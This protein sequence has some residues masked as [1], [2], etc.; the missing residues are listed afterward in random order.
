MSKHKE[1]KPER[2]DYVK[3]LREID[4]YTDIMVEDIM[5]IHTRAEKYARM[6]TTEGLRV[7]DLMS[8][9]VITVG[10]DCSLADAAHL[11]VSK[12]ISGLPVV[13]GEK[14][15]QGIITEADFLRTLGVPSHHPSHSLWQTLE[16]MF[17]H[18][19]V[20][21]EPDEGTVAD[22]MIKDVV[23]VSPEQTLHELLEAMKSHH[24]KRL[25][26][27]GEAREVRGMVTRSDLVRVFFERIQQSGVGGNE[28][29]PPV[30]S[31]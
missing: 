26:V 25:V 15:L 24:I 8:Q 19:L 28:S 10:E 3:A 27:C 31:R 22:L 18:E 11:L 9:P 6:R 30:C 16:A 13:D 17:S 20:L 4:V 12:R 2:E 7:A 5:D 1:I 21:K 29:V 14:R 23:T